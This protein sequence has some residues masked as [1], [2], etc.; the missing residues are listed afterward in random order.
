MGLV[1][2]RIIILVLKVLQRNLVLMLIVVTF[3]CILRII[4]TFVLKKVILLLVKRVLLLL[5]MKFVLARRS[6]IYSMI[7]LQKLLDPQK[8]SLQLLNCLLNVLAA[9]RFM[10]L[11][12]ATVVG[13]MII[14][15]NTL[16]LL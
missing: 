5:L 4:I 3:L 9:T 10:K 13:M 11:C 12:T 7:W 8:C 14:P 6:I 15:F 2:F 16:E 1:T